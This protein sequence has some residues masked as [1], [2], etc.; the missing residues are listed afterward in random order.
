[1]AKVSTSPRMS[2]PSTAPSMLPMPPR[3]TTAPGPPSSI[4]APM[5]GAMLFVRRPD[6]DAVLAREGPCGEERD[7]HHGVHVDSQQP[8]RP[9]VSRRRP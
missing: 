9:L 7:D 6:Q 8:G 1:M 4:C 2:P 5:P 3:I